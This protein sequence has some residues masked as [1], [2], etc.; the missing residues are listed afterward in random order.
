MPS[1]Q[2]LV[3]DLNNGSIL[4]VGAKP[5]AAVTNLE[6]VIS[7]ALKVKHKFVHMNATISGA[8]RLSCAA[9]ATSI[10]FNGSYVHFE[11]GWSTIGNMDINRLIVA[12]GNF[13]G[14]TYKIYRSAPGVFKCVH[15]A[16]PGGV[17]ANALVT[18]MAT[19][20]GQVGWTELV[21]IPTV[22]FIGNN[23][24]TELYVVSQLFYNQRI[25][26]ILLQI[27]S[28]GLIVGRAVTSV[29]V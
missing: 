7:D 14:C 5:D 19:Y 27:N 6:S 26:S 2:T 9:A 15:I 1:I 13:S 20:A 12:S 3:A 21:A 22:G 29:A 8:S 16:R 11:D 24:C 28:Q 10:S 18:S 25:D 23:G 4:G 17:N